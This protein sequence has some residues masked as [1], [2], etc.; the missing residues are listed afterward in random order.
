M[1]GA[2]GVR[3]TSEIG[4]LRRVLCHEPG[5]EL[6]FLTP[7]NRTVYLFDDLLD[8][9][10]A[11]TEHRRFRAILDRFAEVCEVGDLLADVLA[12]PEARSFV[13]T[14]ADEGVREWAE[15]AEPEALAR[16]FVEGKSAEA[17]RAEGESLAELLNEAGYVLPPLPNLFFTR[18]AACVIGDRVVVAAMAHEVRWTEELIMRALFAFHPLLGRADVLYDGTQERGL[19]TSVEGG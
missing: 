14:R 17:S 16:L 5:P 4:P 15:G 10:E 9:E 2:A 6:S 18:D 12:D 11:R 1:A 19:H 7:T 8:M 13:L 3:V